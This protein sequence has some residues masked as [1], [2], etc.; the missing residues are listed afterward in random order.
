MYEVVEKINNFKGLLFNI[1]KGAN[2]G[3]A[4]G[5]ET[6]WPDYILVCIVYLSCSTALTIHTEEP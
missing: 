6:V 4:S 3:D 1:E 5:G 2:I